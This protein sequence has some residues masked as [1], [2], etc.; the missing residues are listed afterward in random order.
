MTYHFPRSS[1]SSIQDQESQKPGIKEKKFVSFTL[2]YINCLQSYPYL[3]EFELSLIT[4]SKIEH[5]LFKLDSQRVHWPT[6]SL[7]DVEKKP[8]RGDVTC[9]RPPPRGLVAELCFN[10]R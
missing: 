1:N 9:P 3:E 8:C 5:C 6:C 7:T 4:V 2:K 10:P